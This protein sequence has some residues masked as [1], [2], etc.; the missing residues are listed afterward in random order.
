MILKKC[1]MCSIEKPA[2]D[3]YPSY[4]K[5]SGKTYLG[6][7]C[8]SCHNAYQTAWRKNN[9]EKFNAIQRRT[10]A[11][12]KSG[13]AEWMKRLRAKRKVYDRK[14]RT[15]FSQ[16]RFD[17]YFEKQGGRCAVCST[18]EKDLGKYVLCADHCHRTNNPRG[19]VCTRCN[20]L[21]SLI[22]I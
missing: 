8:K 10:W 9:P 6:A 16:E 11:K 1:S 2:T 12:A 14:T 17:E 15:F 4:H 22:H 13:Q 3:F 19:L 21:L 7:R 18:H 20:M 5:G